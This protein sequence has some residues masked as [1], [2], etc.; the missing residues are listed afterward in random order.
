L[1]R[2]G[3]AGSQVIVATVA[4]SL[5]QCLGLFRRGKAR[6]GMQVPVTFVTLA[7][8]LGFLAV[9]AVTI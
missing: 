7:I 8:F 2:F 3:E 5:D 1:P 9:L 6:L 4:D